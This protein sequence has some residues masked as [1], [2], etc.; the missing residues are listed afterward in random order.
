M[1][2]QLCAVYYVVDIVK[3]SCHLSVYL[4]LRH[5]ADDF[6]QKDLQRLYGQSIGTPAHHTKRDFNEIAVKYINFNIELSS[7]PPFCNLH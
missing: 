2:G 6:I 5:L 7:Q 1:H 4:Y 3:I